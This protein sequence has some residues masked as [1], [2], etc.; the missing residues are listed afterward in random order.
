MIKS[1]YADDLKLLKNTNVSAEFRLDSRKQPTGGI[2]LY[3]NA[4]KTDNICLKKK[5]TISNLNGKI[6]KLIDRF[7]YLDSNISSTESDFNICIIKA[8]TTIGILAILWKSDL[9]DKIKGYSFLPTCDCVNTTEW[10]NHRTKTKHKIII[11][12]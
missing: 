8:W 9:T 11:L 1:A 7:T 12:D 4:N 5:R 6:P 10:V 2:G 3:V